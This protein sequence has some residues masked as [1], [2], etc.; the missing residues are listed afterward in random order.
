MT[1]SVR[2][3]FIQRTRR[4][5]EMSVLVAEVLRCVILGLEQIGDDEGK[6]F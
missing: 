2:A 3:N 5:G 1:A 6:E 4:S